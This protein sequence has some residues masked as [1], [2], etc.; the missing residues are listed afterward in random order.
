MATQKKIDIHIHTIAYKGIE[1][2]GGGTFASPDEIREMYKQIGVS[3]G[4]ILPVVNPDC[5]FQ[6]QS[7]E[8]AYH[9]T[10][11]HPD[12]FYWFCNIN[13]RNGSNTPDCNLSYFIE[14]YKA[15]GAKGVGEITVLLPF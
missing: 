7:N 14:Y 1:R 15:L 3:K 6:I 11:E 4:V 9:L 10:Q 2:F 8:E 13:P 5:S 12:L